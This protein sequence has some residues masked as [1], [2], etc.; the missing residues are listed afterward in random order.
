MG[1][2]G[3]AVRLIEVFAEL[4]L[5]QPESTAIDVERL[6]T[7]CAGPTPEAT[8]TRAALG[9]AVGGVVA[10]VVALTDPELVVVGGPWGHALLDTIGTFVAGQP[11]PV[12]V[13]A[14]SLTREPAL[15]GARADA[16][17]RLRA[18]IAAAG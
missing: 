1:P 16:L 10:A 5:R 9:R 12:P 15:A 18:S 6:L 13:Q 14:A 2:D 4:G 11:R 17:R 7:R 8:A 3:R